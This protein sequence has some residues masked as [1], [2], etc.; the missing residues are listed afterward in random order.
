[1]DERSHETQTQTDHVLRFVAGQEILGV[2]F[3]NAGALIGPVWNPTTK[4]M[5]A[6]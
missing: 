2:N 5:L 1:M 4:R 3:D 6:N